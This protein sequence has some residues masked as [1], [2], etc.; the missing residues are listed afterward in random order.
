MWWP[1][2][3]RKVP[4]KPPAPVPE[5]QEEEVDTMES[6]LARGMT[7]G[8]A[9]KH[10]LHDVITARVRPANAQARVMQQAVED[11][12]RIIAAI[13]DY[14][15]HHVTP[16]MPSW[17]ALDQDGEGPFITHAQLMLPTLNHILQTIRRQTP[18]F[19]LEEREWVARQ[20]FGSTNTPREWKGTKETLGTHTNLADAVTI[21]DDEDVR[22]WMAASVNATLLRMCVVFHQVDAGGDQTP[23]R[24]F[25][26][27]LPPETYRRMEEEEELAEDDPTGPESSVTAEARAAHAP[28]SQ[29]LWRGW[30]FGQGSDLEIGKNSSHFEAN[31]RC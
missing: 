9:K 13:P 14:P 7:R 15:V 12:A 25:R 1:Q 3:W 30:W 26:N 28:V 17:L 20:I 8:K 4:V 16:H 19:R 27:Y 18:P 2:S 29:L 10:L 23:R 22:L 24:P 5:Q 21:K 11:H 31:F 6:L